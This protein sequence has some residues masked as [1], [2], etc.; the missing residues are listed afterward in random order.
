MHLGA[1]KGC[2]EGSPKP[3]EGSPKPWGS[4]PKCHSGTPK[5]LHEPA[6]VLESAPKDDEGRRSKLTLW[7][8]SFSLLWV[9]NIVIDTTFTFAGGATA[10]TIVSKGTLLM[11]S[12]QTG[13]PR[14]V[15]RVKYL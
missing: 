10:T 4:I 14:Y 6:Y 11:Q 7:K 2:G 9:T 1:S 5:G 3:G 8:L 12:R 15:Q 13:T